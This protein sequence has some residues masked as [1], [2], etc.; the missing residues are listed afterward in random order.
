MKINLVFVRAA[1]L[2]FIWFLT[3]IS[4]GFKA[5]GIAPAATWSLVGIFLPVMGA[6]AL[7]YAYSLIAEAI[8]GHPFRDLMPIEVV[9]PKRNPWTEMVSMYDEQADEQR[10][11]SKLD[12]AARLERQARYEELQER[13]ARATLIE[14]DRRLAKT[15]DSGYSVAF[16]GY[17]G[18]AA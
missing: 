13:A 10:R 9:E 12:K 15:K 2:G 17:D 8:Y 7:V 6:H 18:D 16:D 11:G 3:A 14:R 1:I 4:V 5:A